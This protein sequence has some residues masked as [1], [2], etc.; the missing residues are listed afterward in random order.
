M[1]SIKVAIR[2]RPYTVDDKLGVKIRQVS[3]EEGEIEL[4]NCDYT[5]TRFPFTYAWWSAY[6]YKR[7]LT[8]DNMADADAMELID[9]EA[10]YNQVGMKIKEDLLGGN[11]VVLFAYGLS[12]SG[13]TYTVFG[14]DAIDAPEA[15]FKHKEP[16]KLWDGW[17]ISMKYFQNV[18]DT[19]RDLMSSSA[20]E[21]H[22]KNGMRKD[23][24]GF[25]D[26]E[27]CGTKVL[28]SWNEL[29]TEFQ[30]CNA[31]KAIAPTQFNPMSTRGHCIMVLEVEMPGEAEGMK[32]RGR[33]YVCDL[34]G[35]EPAGDIVYAMYEKIAFDDGSFEYKFK[36]AHADM[37]KTKELQEQMAQ[38]FMKMAEAFK[39]KKLK[40]GASIP[41]CNS[42]F[43]CKYLKDTMLQA[44]TYLFCAIR[45]EG[46]AQ[47]A[48]VVKLAPKKATVA[49]DI[50]L[51]SLAVFKD[52]CK[53][54]LD[55]DGLSAF[56]I[57]GKGDTWRN[58]HRVGEG[59]EEKLNI[60]DRVAVG[61]QLMLF[62]W[63]GNE[64]GCGEPM[65]A[66]DANRSGGGADSKAAAD[67]LNDERKRILEEREKWEQE[68]TQQTVDLLNRVTMTF[69]VVL[70]KD[71][72]VPER[73]DP[74]YL[75]FDNDFHLG[76]ATHW[77]EYLLY[78][79]ETDEEEKMQDPWTYR[80]EIKRACDLPVFC[81]MAYAVQ[82]T[83]FSPVFDYTRVHH[84]PSVS[85]EFIKY[86]KGSVEMQIHDKIGTANNIVAES[87]R[88]GEPK[89]Y[90]FAEAKRPKTEAEVRCEQL[91]V[92][93]ALANE[94]NSKLV[95]RIK[96]LEQ[97]LGQ[98]STNPKSRQ[99]LSSALMI[100][101]IVNGP[102]DGG[103]E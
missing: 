73:H 32:L 40:P 56:L 38:F 43:L 88:T 100:D 77:P 15:W 36:G 83:T 70:E 20:E 37:K 48:S 72:E 35:T 65:T 95:N 42:F 66:E 103:A 8:G 46:F 2:C 10:A 47:N 101:S 102:S 94:E 75:M 27:W 68:K 62:R 60:F 57:G 61:D 54:R 99:L 80:L 89:G 16:H 19:V 45:P 63:P 41:G 39:A 52:H 69:D 91:T 59:I 92:S 18:V 58:G 17:K 87:I 24:D 34:A 25:M 74:L 31:R 93:L 84:V 78:N 3:D 97:M 55:Q 22:Y 71:Y 6:G 28:N 82:Q 81:E 11:A 98:I 51:M 13:K 21:Q 79:L 12:G 50:Q 23:P 30:V 4:I 26:I 64:E 90:D 29:R 67:E 53:V 9:Q 49:G 1:T 33:V 14:P 86:L 44:R 76:T 7:H 85:P 96:E 5:T